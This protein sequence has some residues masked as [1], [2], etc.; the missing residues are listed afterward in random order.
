MNWKDKYDYVGNFT[1]G[2]AWVE[3]KDKAGFVDK[4]GKVVIPLIYDSVGYF[5]EGLAKVEL[6]GIAG[7]I[8]RTGKVVK[9]QKDLIKGV[10][11]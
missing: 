11:K 6:N 9:G 3:L 2:L 4:T 8:D 5:T 10:F 7:L 1:E